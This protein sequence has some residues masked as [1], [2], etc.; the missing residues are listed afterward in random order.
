[1]GECPDPSFPVVSPVA[2][3]DLTRKSL[4]G[5]KVE[6][7]TSEKMASS[8][9]LSE[10]SASQLEQPQPNLEH[11]S[12]GEL[13]WSK[14]L[15]PQYEPPSVS[16]E[17]LQPLQKMAVVVILIEDEEVNPWQEALKEVG[18]H[19]MSSGG[20]KRSISQNQDSRGQK[21]S[22]SQNLDLGKACGNQHSSESQQ[23]NPPGESC[24]KPTPHGGDVR[25]LKD[26]TVPQKTSPEQIPFQ[27]TECGKLF[28]RKSN[29][30]QHQRMHKSYKCTQC[31]KSFNHNSALTQHQEMHCGEHTFECAVCGD[32]FTCSS[33]LVIHQK[34]HSKEKPYRCT[35]C[36]ECFLT[37]PEL[38]SHWGLHT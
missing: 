5:F 4:C 27:Y 33:S 8:R 17:D 35:E 2:L 30:L 11:I 20:Q 36:R 21:R 10:S 22:V 18:V 6:E 13:I 25:D 23:G 3:S 37:I 28:S 14:P 9:A 29:L 19:E 1:M 12:Q 16:R 38:V 15:E 7:V 26:I 32:H 34:I 24:S 31:W